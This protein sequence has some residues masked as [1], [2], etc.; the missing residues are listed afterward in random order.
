[1]T[2]EEQQDAALDAVIA[3]KQQQ[4]ADRATAV[5]KKAVLDTKQS[6]LDKANA[7]QLLALVERNGALQSYFE[8]NNKA[9]SDD[10]VSIAKAAQAYNEAMQNHGLILT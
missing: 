8:A 2:A 4:K 10:V 1:M 9:E 5:Q 3:A 6:A 7:T